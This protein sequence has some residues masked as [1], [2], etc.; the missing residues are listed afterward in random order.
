MHLKGLGLN[1]TSES[2]YRSDDCTKAGI[3]PE[4]AFIVK[5]T[6]D[7]SVR[8]KIL[9]YPQVKIVG[10]PILDHNWQ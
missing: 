4:W 10:L 9:R 3:V 2:P 6:K 8:S 5:N 7:R 1:W